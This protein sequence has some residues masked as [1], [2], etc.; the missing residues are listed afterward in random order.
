[1]CLSSL[2]W[3][4]FREIRYLFDYKETAEDFSM[5]GDLAILKELFGVQKT[6]HENAF[7]L[8]VSMRS[9][10]ERSQDRDLYIRE[11]EE[12]KGLYTALCIKVVKW[13]I[14]KS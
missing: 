13:K 4:G 6:R 7:L 9:M 14:I 5:P 11:I 2:A 3:G 1:M 10:A 12:S 8:M